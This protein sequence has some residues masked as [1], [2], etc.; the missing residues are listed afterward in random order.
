M[1]ALVFHHNSLPEALVVELTVRAVTGHLRASADWQ[2]APE[3][4]R[5]TDSTRST[6]PSMVITLE[7]KIVQNTL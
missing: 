6:R 4:N 1:N 5:S 7:R 2:P 3:R